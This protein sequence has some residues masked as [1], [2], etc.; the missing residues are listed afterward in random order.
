MYR[1][2][3]CLLIV[4]SLLGLT[5]LVTGGSDGSS[6]RQPISVSAAPQR[7]G[8]DELHSEPKLPLQAGGDIS[9]TDALAN[10]FDF[11]H[12][13]GQSSL[14][15]FK[16]ADY[17]VIW[18]SQTSASRATAA[19]TSPSQAAAA[20]IEIDESDFSVALIEKEGKT[21]GP[22][23]V[24][25]Q[26]DLAQVDLENT[27]SLNVTNVRDDGSLPL[28][29][30]ITVEVGELEFGVAYDPSRLTSINL[31]NE[32]LEIWLGSSPGSMLTSVSHGVRVRRD[33]PGAFTADCW[34]VQV[35][36]LSGL[37]R[38][39]AAIAGSAVTVT[40][41]NA[42]TR[43]V[44]DQPV[45]ADLSL[46][47]VDSSKPALAVPIGGFQVSD[48]VVS[49]PRLSVPP[50]STG[51]SWYPVLDVPGFQR[52]TFSESLIDLPADKRLSLEP[53][54]QRRLRLLDQSGGPIRGF[55]AIKE[56]E[57]RRKRLRW[58]GSTDSDGLTGKVDWEGGALLVQREG[59]TVG[60]F[61]ILV[62]ETIAEV[63]ASLLIQQQVIDVVLPVQSGS[64]LVRN[65]PEPGLELVAIDNSG[66]YSRARATDDGEILFEGLPAGAYRLETSKMFN[67][68]QTDFVRRVPTD[69]LIFIESEGSNPV[70][71]EWKSIWA[72]NEPIQG[73]IRVRNERA[74]IVVMIVPIYHRDGCRLNLNCIP[75][76]VG[77]NG[78]YTIE[79]G[80]PIPHCML[81][82]VPT[83]PPSSLP[84]IRTQARVEVIGVTD[85]GESVVLDV[86][87]IELI[88][89]REL[90]DEIPI[91]VT[92]Q[93]TACAELTSRGIT[94][95]D[96]P[97]TISTF[98]LPS[99]QS[100]WLHDPFGGPLGLKVLAGSR[101][102]SL[103]RRVASGDHDSIAI[104]F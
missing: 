74:G 30:L 68:A 85:P 61:G 60:G 15:S 21:Y 83:T 86:N 88:R 58:S 103:G 52:Y 20:F 51:S 63:P 3:L 2:T 11:G 102:L 26:E 16:M 44:V 31:P 98:N 67:S 53:V 89:S 93:F 10:E 66:G 69:Q 24:N 87:R 37:D 90:G 92:R 81:A 49:V 13:T 59:D 19:V 27:T 47:P 42:S 1:N 36:D 14:E 64:L 104:K 17:S 41:V 95:V 34:H 57:G 76:Q 73:S 12:N 101:P 6:N 8:L 100:V 45:V 91:S 7:L 56:V 43:E 62:F 72:A 33:L 55:Y 32:I 39:D 78:T 18:L 35:S 82:C 94:F 99:K 38:I 40:L 96:G 9:R 70:V 75:D 97:S 5:F 80:E 79:V 71:T 48:G 65:V 4:A 28:A 77:E 22:F 84:A 29:V 50:G 46:V 54:S 23:F 25:D